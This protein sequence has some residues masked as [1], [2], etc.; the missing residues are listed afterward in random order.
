M[1]TEGGRRLHRVEPV[2]VSRRRF[3]WTAGALAALVPAVAIRLLAQDAAHGALPVLYVAVAKVPGNSFAGPSHL[4]H[5]RGAPELIARS[6]T[7]ADPDLARRLWTAS[8]QLTS[9]RSRSRM[10]FSSHEAEPIALAVNMQDRTRDPAVSNLI[11]PE[12]AARRSRQSAHPGRA[13]ATSKEPTGCQ[14][15]ASCRQ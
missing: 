6:A 11:R 3:L 7:A 13:V 15:R 8:E 12:R 9:V 4:A 2:A 14:E 10:S 5:M 1:S